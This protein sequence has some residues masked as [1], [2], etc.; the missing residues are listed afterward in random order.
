M[1]EQIRYT[2]ESELKMWDYF[3]AEN[4]GVSLFWYYLVL[5]LKSETVNTISKT[6]K[7]V[8]DEFVNFV[9]NYPAS[10]A[11]SS[12]LFFFFFNFCSPSFSLRF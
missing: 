5:L 2:G 10:E 9:S 7:T 8:Q 4:S 3:C 6:T 11:V 12:S 1:T